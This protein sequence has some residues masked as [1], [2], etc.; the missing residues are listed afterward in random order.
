MAAWEVGPPWSR[1]TA[2]T[3][4][5]LSRSGRFRRKEVVG[6]EDFSPE[7]L[8]RDLVRAGVQVAVDAGQNV[9]DVR[10]A[11]P[12]VIVADGRE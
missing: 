2:N 3:P 7:V 1:T 4:P 9:G 12:D 11:L 6:H 5:W 10:L 8:G